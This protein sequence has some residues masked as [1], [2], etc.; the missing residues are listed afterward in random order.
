[1]FHISS[2]KGFMFSQQCLIDS[3][4]I[5]LH[6]GKS[7]LRR[8]EQFNFVIDFYCQSLIDFSV[9]EG[10]RRTR[11]SV[12]QERDLRRRQGEVDQGLRRRRGL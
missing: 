3:F 10:F 2:M 4:L 5:Y 8:N 6:D 7:N 9:L 1:M 12:R 11:T